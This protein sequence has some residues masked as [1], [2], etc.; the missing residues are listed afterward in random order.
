[1]MFSHPHGISMRMPT[2]PHCPPQKTRISRWSDQ[3]VKTRGL[4]AARARYQP[5]SPLR[6]RGHGCTVR[7]SCCDGVRIRKIF[8]L[9]RQG[10]A[11]GMPS[12]S[13]RHEGAPCTPRR[14]KHKVLFVGKSRIEILPPCEFFPRPQALTH[15]HDVARRGDPWQ[16]RRLAMMKR[17]STTRAARLSGRRLPAVRL[18]PEGVAHAP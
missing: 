2:A 5:S 13:E 12:Q 10:V 14:L 4:D 18:E 3:V 6:P 17:C 16:Q 7:V 8:C 15:R 9:S 11:H 1:M